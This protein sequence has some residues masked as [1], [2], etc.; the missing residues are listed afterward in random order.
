[1]FCQLI[2][3]PASRHSLAL[4]SPA[5]TLITSIISRLVHSFEAA[6]AASGKEIAINFRSLDTA[7]HAR[8]SLLYS[9]KIRMNQTQ[10]NTASD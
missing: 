3:M 1:M 10:V 5:L 8:S 9:R 6:V 7:E 4:K 2:S